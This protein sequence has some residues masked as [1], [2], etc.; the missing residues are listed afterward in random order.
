[1]VQFPTH[2]FPPLSLPALQTFHTLCL[3][4]SRWSRGEWKVV[5]G[6]G[7]AALSLRWDSIFCSRSLCSFE[8][9]TVKICS[10]G[11]VLCASPTP[12]PPLS[13]CPQPHPHP[14]Q[15]TPNV[16]PSTPLSPVLL[17]DYYSQSKSQAHQLGHIYSGL[18]HLELS[19]VRPEVTSWPHAPPSL[20]LH[21][22]QGEQ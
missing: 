6:G 21:C 5:A 4:D 19:T 7:Q 17:P 1:M 12:R 9:M 11:C 15:P 3:G 13:F 14:H 2:V 16:S 8:E 18:W 10:T 22:K 20:S